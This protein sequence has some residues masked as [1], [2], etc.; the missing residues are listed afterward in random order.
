MKK[1][2]EI[3][4]SLY[5]LYYLTDLD[6]DVILKVQ[7]ENGLMEVDDY[8]LFSTDSG[9]LI[10]FG[11]SHLN[12]Y[13]DYYCIHSSGVNK[14]QSL[15]YEETYDIFD[16]E[17]GDTI[18]MYT[19][20][21][22]IVIPSSS[23]KID[24]TTPENLVRCDYNKYGPLAFY[25][26]PNQIAI[27]RVRHVLSLSGIGHL[28]CVNTNNA[29]NPNFGSQSTN[30]GGR[31]LTGGIKSIYEWAKVHE[32]P[33]N[34]D[35]NIATKAHKFLQ[36][37]GIPQD[38]L[39]DVVNSQV[40]MRVAR[41]IKEGSTPGYHIDEV[42]ET[43]QSLKDFYKSVCRYRNLFNIKR[44]HSNGSSIPD[45]VIANEIKNI[46]NKLYLICIE[47][48]IFDFS[49]DSMEDY[50][51]SGLIKNNLAMAKNLYSI[52]KDFYNT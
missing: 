41:Y 21:N 29:E 33:F 36:E 5:E 13:H 4:I 19:F 49:F 27:T 22:S 45:S 34:N 1:I 20:M 15:P 51:N 40:D 9:T 35:E 16:Q 8:D 14:I 11:K 28:L 38:V 2:E 23:Q 42:T 30:T 48:E 25:D 24:N 26:A 37:V 47:N 6:G 10:A 50:L 18:T 43:P 12:G 7:T 17:L 52:L 44:N 32:E 46:E 31:T 39:M 3:D